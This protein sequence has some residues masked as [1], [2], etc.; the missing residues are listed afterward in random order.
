MVRTAPM[1]AA[2]HAGAQE[3]GRGVD[4]RTRYEERCELDNVG[5]RRS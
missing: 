1:T 5:H 2:V 3:T 4:R